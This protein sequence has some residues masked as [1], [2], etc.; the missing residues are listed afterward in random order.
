[1]CEDMLERIENEPNLL[2]SVVTLDGMW[3]FT[4]DPESKRQSMQW[5]STGSSRPKKAQMSEFKAMLTV[6]SDINGIVMIESE[7]PV[8]RLLINTSRLKY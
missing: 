5:K 7:L 2:E 4:Y 1:M 6:F 3:T 8:V